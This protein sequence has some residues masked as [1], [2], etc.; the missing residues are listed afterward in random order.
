MRNCWLSS[1]GSCTTCTKVVSFL[2][3]RIVWL[4]QGYLSF[5]WLISVLCRA[6]VWVR[7]AHGCHSWGL[8]RRESQGSL[9]PLPVFSTGNMLAMLQAKNK[10]TE[11]SWEEISL[12]SLW[13]SE[14]EIFLPPASNNVQVLV[15]FFIVLAWLAHLKAESKSVPG[16][17]WVAKKRKKKCFSKS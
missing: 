1:W 17:L 4:P 3:P 2:P 5:R 7:T 8:S 14:R 11:K 16:P 15:F 13:F 9:W 12:K 10:Q 6:A